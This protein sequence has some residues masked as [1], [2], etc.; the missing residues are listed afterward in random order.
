MCHAFSG[1]KTGDF[2]KPLDDMCQSRARF[3]TVFI[4]L[5]NV[6]YNNTK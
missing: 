4:G 1:H 6:R 5:E 3:G 2:A